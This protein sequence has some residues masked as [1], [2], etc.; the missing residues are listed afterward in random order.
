M[1]FPENNRYEH[2]CKLFYS[3]VTMQVAFLYLGST[4]L[5][6]NI[7][8]ARHLQLKKETLIEYASS[9]IER[10]LCLYYFSKKILLNQAL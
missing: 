5:S 2:Q 4:S 7:S 9:L 8:T 6:T 3:Q 1:A 10:T